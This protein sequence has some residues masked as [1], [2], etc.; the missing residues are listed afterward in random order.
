M[1]GFTVLHVTVA[2]TV[3]SAAFD[4][5]EAGK[6]R[7]VIRAADVSRSSRAAFLPVRG[8]SLRSPGLPMLMILAVTL[9]VTVFNDAEQGFDTVMD[10]E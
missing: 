4:F 5:T 8:Y 6:W 1:L 10:I 3:V 2:F 9:A 7:E